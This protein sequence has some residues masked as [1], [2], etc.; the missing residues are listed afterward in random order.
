MVDPEGRIVAAYGKT[1]LFD[2]DTA[3]GVFHESAFTR[4]GERLVA[5]AGTPAGTL[6]LSVCYDLR[7]PALYAALRAVGASVL[8]IP[9]AFMPR[10]V[11]Y[12]ADRRNFKQR[13]T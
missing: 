1:H 4:P 8:L 3:D 13:A 7:F 2:V 9:S 5:V 10:C 12:E 6:G 11:R